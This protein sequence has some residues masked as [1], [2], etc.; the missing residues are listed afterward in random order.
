MGI[1]ASDIQWTNTGVYFYRL[2][3]GKIVE[4]DMVF[5]VLGH[6]RQLGAKIVPPETGE[7]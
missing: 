7:G 3:G 6:L 5:K 2:A 4:D 1:P